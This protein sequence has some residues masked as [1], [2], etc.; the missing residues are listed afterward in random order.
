MYKYLHKI[1]VDYFFYCVECGIFMLKESDVMLGSVI[2]I[3]GIILIDFFPQSIDMVLLGVA[4]IILLTK[5]ERFIKEYEIHLYLLASV[6]A[7]LSIFFYDNRFLVLIDNGTLGLSFLLV[8]MFT[9][10]LPNGNTFSKLLK[11]NRKILSILGFVLIAPHAFLNVFIQMQ[12]DIFGIVA[13]V[14]MIPL[15]ITSFIVIRKEIKPSDWNKIHKISYLAYISIFIHVIYMGDWI[16][17]IIYS[18]LFALYINN[19]LIK[20]LKK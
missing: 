6:Y 13:F 14:V 16:N 4:I 12:I 3:F 15:F 5:F 20:E 19:K 17:K 2:V 10:V 8:V 18:V 1:T 9:G 7:V 11:R